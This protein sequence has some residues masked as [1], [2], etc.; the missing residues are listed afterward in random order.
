[1][2][3]FFY[4]SRHFFFTKPTRARGKK[5]K[6]PKK[7]KTLGQCPWLPD[8]R[9]MTYQSVER[10][11]S[12]V[13]FL[14]HNDKVKQLPVATKVGLFLVLDLSSQAKNVLESSTETFINIA[15]AFDSCRDRSLDGKLDRG[16]DSRPN[17]YPDVFV[18]ARP[19]YYQQSLRS[20]I[21]TERILAFGFQWLDSVTRL[22]PPR[23]TALRC[24][25]SFGKCAWMASIM[26]LE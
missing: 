12:F 13:Y 9:Q 15:N 11:H 23:K 8:R 24:F 25:Q 10:S 14:P 5:T 16:L 1:M 6:C 26:L 7:K 19:H 4:V 3:F 21:S 22:L 18:K 20:M 2:C 17:T